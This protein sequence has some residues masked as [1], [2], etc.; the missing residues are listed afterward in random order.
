MGG[1]RI[2]TSRPAARRVTEL[3]GGGR[4]LEV[5]SQ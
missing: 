2:K 1:S 3:G 4:P 5:F